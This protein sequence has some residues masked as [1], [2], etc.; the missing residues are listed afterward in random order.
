[1]QKCAAVD[2]FEKTRRQLASKWFHTE[3]QALFTMFFCFVYQSQLLL[4]SMGNLSRET[5]WIWLAILI[6]GQTCWANSQSQWH[7]ADHAGIPA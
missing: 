6:L 7:S 2:R 3:Y 5:A 4:T 1:M